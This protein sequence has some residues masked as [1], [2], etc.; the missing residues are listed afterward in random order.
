MVP[1]HSHRVSR[2]RRYLG[3]NWLPSLFAYETITL[4]GGPSHALL[5]SYRNTVMLSIP[6]EYF[7]SRFSLLRVRSPLLTESQLFSLPT[8]TEMFHFPAFALPPS[9]FM[10]QYLPYGRRVPPFRNLPITGYLPP[11]RS[12]SQAITSFFA[13]DCQGI[14]HMHL[15]T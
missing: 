12:F 9:L 7:Y 14:H 15:I 6:R 1:P 5:L 11:P 3:Y 13:S 4:C 2:V 8:G 10:Y